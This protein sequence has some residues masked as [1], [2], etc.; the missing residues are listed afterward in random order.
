[1]LLAMYELESNP[2]YEQVLKDQR[3]LFYKRLAELQETHQVGGIPKHI[4]SILKEYFGTKET[5]CPICLELIKDNLEV[6]PCGHFFCGDCFQKI[7]NC[8]M[9]RTP[10]SSSEQALCHNDGK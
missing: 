2:R 6:S 3:E 10:M 1:M 9:C 8:A 7:H 4:V 5:Q